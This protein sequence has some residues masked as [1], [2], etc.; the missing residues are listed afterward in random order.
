ME[1]ITHRP[2]DGESMSLS[3]YLPSIEDKIVDG[4][5][6]DVITQTKCPLCGGI[7]RI[8]Y[9]PF[10]VAGTVYH[11]WLCK[12]NMIYLAAYPAKQREL[13]IALRE[14]A[15][16]VLEPMKTHSY[17]RAARVAQSLPGGWKINSHLD[18]GCGTEDLIDFLEEKYGCIGEGVDYDASLCH[19]H[20]IY[21]L[22]EEVEKTYDLVTAIHVLEHVPDPLAFL[23]EIARV[24]HGYIV[25]EVPCV[26]QSRD[27]S[28]RHINVFSPW[29]L[30]RMIAKAAIKIMKIEWQQVVKK[31]GA[32][33]II[34][35][36]GEV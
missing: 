3:T 31:V 15:G 27:E 29:T 5:L 17:R 25:I 13:Y 2:A 6:L 11:Y 19:S 4:E 34:S 10:N 12:C 7:D 21:G 8:P 23:R 24:A 28:I 30:E 35:F 1:A 36:I 32:Q 33:P 20:K 18:V 9:K 26:G 16:P 14:S 22:I